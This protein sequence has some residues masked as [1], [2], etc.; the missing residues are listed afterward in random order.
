ME[1]WSADAIKS[2]RSAAEIDG[3]NSGDQ[4]TDE[5]GR[6]SDRAAV[7]EATTG[8]Q[9]EGEWISGRKQTV[10]WRRRREAGTG[11]GTGG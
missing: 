1:L 10:W 5:G 3:S 2:G 7:A 11:A 4:G 8:M 9:V 6:Q